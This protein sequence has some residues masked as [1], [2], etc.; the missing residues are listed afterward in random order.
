MSEPQSGNHADLFE[1]KDRVNE[2]MQQLCDARI[3][4]DGLFSNADAG[5]DGREYRLALERHGVFANVCPN[6]RNG[7]PSEDYLYDPELY[8]GRWV[9]ERTNAW[10]DGFRS[11][12]NRFDT[13][14][15]S[16]K[17]W[18]FLAFAIVFLKKFH[19]FYSRR[20]LLGIVLLH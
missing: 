5:F 1:I 19:L 13:T 2:L 14:V 10:M 3:Q 18:N 8:K 16:W 17:G 20:L 6:R 7:E 11:I 12:L 15:T 9:V 4:I